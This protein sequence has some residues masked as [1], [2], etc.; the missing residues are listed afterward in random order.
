VEFLRL[1]CG[2]I[3]LLHGFG[4]VSALWGWI[5]LILIVA[6]LGGLHPLSAKFSAIDYTVVGVWL[7]EVVTV[8]FSSLPSNGWAY[9]EQLSLAIAAYFSVS[10]L[11][12]SRSRSILGLF[13]CGLAISAAIPD[14]LHF[15]RRYSE[16]QQLDFGSIA[17]VRQSLTVVG[18]KPAGV[19]Y[20][21]YLVFL[22]WGLASLVV[23]S[24][25]IWS[26][27][28]GSLAICAA[29]T[30]ILISLSRGIYL[31]F[32]V[33]ACGAYV[34]LR[35]RGR[36]SLLAEGRHKTISAAA[37]LLMLGL[38]LGAV[39]GNSLAASAT[40]TTDSA[41][42]SVEGRFFL[43]KQVLQRASGRPL[44]GFG[45]RTLVLYGTEGITEVSGEAVDRAFS[46]P[47]QLIF[48]RGLIGVLVYSCFFFIVFH[49]GFA[50]IRRVQ[51]FRNPSTLR[52]YCFVLAAI[53]ALLIRD[54]TYTTL[55][56]DK[57]VTVGLFTLVAL[58]NVDDRELDPSY[59]TNKLLS[60]TL[61]ALTI[62]LG[63]IVTV[64]Q[65]REAA[66]DWYAAE[67]VNADSLHDEAGAR[68]RMLRSYALASNPYFQAQAGLFSSRTFGIILQENGTALLATNSDPQ[69]DRT[70][71]E[72][73]SSYKFSL[74]AFPREA[75]WQHNLGWL[76]WLGGDHAPGI[77]SVRQA[78]KLEPGTA[79]YRESLILMLV[80][81][82]DLGAAEN[83]LVSLLTLAPEIVDSRWWETL[84]S[85][86]PQTTHFALQRA[87][88]TLDAD[89][90]PD[91]VQIARKGRLY[92][93]IG[94]A[95]A[96]QPLLE[97]SLQKL[98]A[99]SGAWRNYGILL[100][101]GGDWE[102]AGKALER[103]VFLDP[104]DSPAY[105]ALSQV[106]LHLGPQHSEV[107]PQMNR[108]SAMFRTRAARTD[109]AS[110]R[111]PESLR[112]SRRLQ[113]QTPVP[114][115]LVV[116]GLLQFCTPLMTREY[117]TLVR[118]RA[119]ETP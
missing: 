117:E 33:S 7:F 64:H 45:A 17:D 87:I 60:L 6:T 23:S 22:A 76:I 83:E 18:P 79:L 93:E 102:N 114:D 89:P 68:K 49:S 19:H 51:S 118:S 78:V 119:S 94:D 90:H 109:A 50:H 96:A 98:P 97:K 66:A 82:S 36:K 113:I 110:R 55:F 34:A 31:A 41:R 80:Q 52:L 72:A 57:A 25:P 77:Q 3:L 42:R 85:S 65:A 20:T 56:D 59:K 103:A 84:V 8:R 86:R 37:L 39:S 99:M 58:L 4:Y 69:N 9:I 40:P 2:A 38:S 115:D 16:W 104:W 5:G 32:I 71:A 105:Y 28:A 54:L 101:R 74:N 14:T 1:V 81:E 92:M 61:L 35:S 24:A 63:A 73:E 11:K 107:S 12:L 15:L 43:W 108:L 88:S 46:F 10:R 100:A 91:P 75:A 53:G 21:I 106:V 48:E 62:A 112:A 70:L 47:A 30:G 29:L 67:A 116:E 95:K 27:L 111:S 26:R 13:V 44:L